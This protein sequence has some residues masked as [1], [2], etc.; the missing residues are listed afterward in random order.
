MIKAIIVDAGGVLYLN[1]AG[2]GFVN[3]P[4]VE[5]IRANQK[6]FSFGI[7]STTTYDLKTILKKDKISDLFKF[8]LTSGET[9]FDKI[10]PFI[11]QKALA[12]LE[13]TSKETIFIDNDEE[14]I[15]TASAIGIKTILYTDFEACKTQIENLINVF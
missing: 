8:I 14:Y 15:K 11:Y 6:R 13:T 9:G 3:T 7:I 2:I 10:E 12:L 1:R 4:L 5:F